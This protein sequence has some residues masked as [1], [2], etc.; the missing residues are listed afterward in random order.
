MAADRE[1]AFLTESGVERVARLSRLALE[2]EEFERLTPQLRS[3]L[4][5]IERIAEIPEADLPVPEEPAATPL[6]ADVPF[7]GDG[8]RELH[9]NAGIVVHGHV[10]VPRVVDS[11]R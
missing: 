11:S 8:R 5:H 6:R 1:N 4:H 3:I 2:P 10:P 9:R 7:P